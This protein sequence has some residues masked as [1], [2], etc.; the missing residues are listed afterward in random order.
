MSAVAFCLTAIA[1]HAAASAAPATPATT[2]APAADA[3]DAAWVRYHTV[4]KQQY[5]RIGASESAK[6]PQMRTQG[7]YFLQGL[8][9]TGFNMYIAPR[10]QFPALYLHQVF[11][12]FELSWGL[13]NPDFLYRWTFLDGKKSYRI[14]GSRK[15]S[16][17]ATLQVMRGFWGDQLEGTLANV[18]FDDLPANADGSFEIF[19]GPNP[20][21]ET[22]GK[23]WV[24]TD[25]A[26]DNI[27]L[28]MRETFVDWS[29]DVPMKVQIE[30][31][32]RD[33]DA[34]LNLTPEQLAA[35]IDKLTAW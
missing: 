34:T 24:K 19:L 14:F 13:P 30:I 25:P 32:D 28:N 29:N 5:D 2:P 27:V 22:K 20:P 16:G 18:N 17:W 4:M 26:S 23:Y 11:M 10:Q 35:R 1:P 31:L 15:S 8:Q 21:A 7:I 33:P 6:N 12:P 9:A 3:V